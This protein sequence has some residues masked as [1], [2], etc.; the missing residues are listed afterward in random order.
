ME[1]RHTEPAS[2]FL[3]EQLSLLRQ[4]GASVVCAQSSQ[5]VCLAGKEEVD[6]RGTFVP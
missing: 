5:N 1:P 2:P 6:I 3:Q 4:P